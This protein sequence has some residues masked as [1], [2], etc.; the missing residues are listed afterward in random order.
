VKPTDDKTH[1]SHPQLQTN[2]S[3]AKPKTL[4]IDPPTI[5]KWMPRENRNEVIFLDIDPDFIDENTIRIEL[6]VVFRPIAIKRGL[7][8]AKDYYVGSTGAHVIFETF[9]GQ[10]KDYTRAMTMP[11]DY[12]NTYKRG[13]KASV[14]LAPKIE[15]G[16]AKGEAGEI[17]LAKDTECTFTT[18]F[19]GSERVLADVFLGKGVEWDFM[20]PPGQ[21]L[22]DYVFGNLYLY[23]EA[24]WDT[25][26]K[27]GVIEVNASDIS[28]FNSKRRLIANGVKAVGMRLALW[29][30]GINLKRDGIVVNFREA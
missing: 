21:V 23:V 28:F 4:F 29:R 15:A 9:S 26:R 16:E 12:E 1:D 2:V 13:R 17:E 27:E 25:K 18:K 22:R 10:V 11:V 3:L 7:I 30:Q 20:L 6:N 5:L 14:K 19:S 8:Q 24:S